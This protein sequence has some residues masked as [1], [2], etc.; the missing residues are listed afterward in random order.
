MPEIGLF[1]SEGGAPTHG[2][3]T[4]SVSEASRLT[5]WLRRPLGA[6]RERLAYSKRGVPPYPLAAASPRSKPGRL[7]YSK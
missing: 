4:L 6:S 3:P 5:L 1:G 2:V 7:A